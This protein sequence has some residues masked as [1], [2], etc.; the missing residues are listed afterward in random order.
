MSK[1][2]FSLIGWT[3][4]TTLSVSFA[5][6]TNGLSIKAVVDPTVF[7]EE[8]NRSSRHIHKSVV[9]YLESCTTRMIDSA[10]NVTLSSPSE[11]SRELQKLEVAIG[12]L[13]QAVLELERLRR[14][15]QAKIYRKQEGT[16]VI[17]A[18]FENASS[19]VRAGLEFSDLYPETPLEIRMDLMEG[20]ADL[21]ALHR[22][23]TKT[24]K[25]GHGNLSRV[26]DVLSAALS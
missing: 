10:A 1:M 8:S 20:E 7:A 12:R 6:V 2:T 16:F 18:D 19:H 9:T 25:P 26:F 5:T 17:T 13:D 11:I 22:E 24:A 14:R 3:P 4:K 21:D 23:L 15:Y